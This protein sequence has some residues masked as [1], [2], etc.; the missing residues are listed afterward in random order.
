MPQCFEA[1]ADASPDRSAGVMNRQKSSAASRQ[2]RGGSRKRRSSKTRLSTKKLSSKR[3][4]SSKH[5]VTPNKSYVPKMTSFNPKPVGLANIV[6]VH[7]N[8]FKSNKVQLDKARISCGVQS[9]SAWPRVRRGSSIKAIPKPQPGNVEWVTKLSVR[10]EHPVATNSFHSGPL[11]GHSRFSVA[12]NQVRLPRDQQVPVAGVRTR[13]FPPPREKQHKLKLLV[14]VPLK[15]PA[16]MT[17][18]RF[19]RRPG[20]VPEPRK[21]ALLE[22]KPSSRSSECKRTSQSSTG[23]SLWSSTPLIS[24]ARLP[25]KLS[26]MS[27]FAS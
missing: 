25:A 2:Q 26:R 17:T 14:D 7:S 6:T 21:S 18:P 19:S 15:P 9:A 13:R 24:Q 5:D 23:T 12:P 22:T 3:R 11:E 20:C 27:A 10:L 16:P 4:S 8:K 1:S